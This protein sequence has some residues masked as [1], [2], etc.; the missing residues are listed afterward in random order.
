MDSRLRVTRLRAVLV[1]AVVAL[2]SAAV[3]YATIPDAAGVIHGCYTKKGGVLTVIDPSAGQSCSPLQT[4][5]NWNQQGPK[6]DPGPQGVAGAQGDP[7][8]AGTERCLRDGA[9]WQ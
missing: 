6:G 1:V 3:A 9:H 5:L 8:A 7:G 4:P 2:V